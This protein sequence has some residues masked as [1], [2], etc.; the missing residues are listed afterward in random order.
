MS[1]EF[2][3]FDKAP[4][5]PVV[6]ISRWSFGLREVILA[7]IAGILL[8]MCLIL[9]G[10]FGSTNEKLANVPT[11]SAIV[12]KHYCTSV[13]CLKTATRAS[14]LMNKS[15]DPC[16]NFYQYACGNYKKLKSAFHY[17][18]GRNVILDLRE[19]NEDRIIDIMEQ[20]IST[21][22]DNAAE[23]KL[24]K[25]FRSCND[26]YTREKQRGL[27]FLTQVLPELGGWKVLGTWDKDWDVSKALKKV[28]SDFW[29]DALY[30]PRVEYNKDDGEGKIISLS[31]AGTGKLMYPQWY[32]Q[33]YYKTVV[34]DYKKFIRRVGQLLVRDAATFLNQTQSNASLTEELLEEFVNDTYTMEYQIAA[35]DAFDPDDLEE[36][37]YKKMS[38]N[39][40]KGVTNNVIDWTEQLS[41]LFNEARITGN[42]EVEVYNMGYFSGLSTY[43]QSL[44]VQD[45]KRILH[46]YFIW[47]VAESY[48]Q[49]MSWEYIHANREVYVDL[50][51]RPNFSGLYRYCFVV[52]EHHMMDALNYLYIEQFMSKENKQTAHD[53]TDNIRL[54]LKTQI[55]KTP[56]MDERTRIYAQEKLDQLDLKIGYPDWMANQGEIDDM[57]TSLMVNQ[58]DFFGNLLRMN[59]FRRKLW[60]EHL[61]SRGSGHEEWV[62]AAYDTAA[63]YSMQYNEVAAPAGFLQFPIYDADQPHFSSFG[64]FGSIMGK[65]LH[66]FVDEW[67]KTVDKNGEF[68]FTEKGLGSWWSNFTETQYKPAKQ[69]VRNVYSNI[70]RTVLDFNDRWTTIKVNASYAASHA[71]NWISGVK[72]ALLGY[73]DWAMKKTLSERVIP[74]LDMSYD[75]MIFLAHAQT[76]CEVEGRWSFYIFGDLNAELKVNMA[77][78]QMK[79]FSKAFQCKKNAKMNHVKKCQYY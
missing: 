56:W 17:L 61:N 67:G 13:G 5:I 71:I 19:Q 77:L 40:L 14:S 73:Q 18:V 69:C 75:Q 16:E 15:V 21:F 48:V 2:K 78:G 6:R 4:I 74:G 76:N 32:L 11:A 57:Y 9:A 43:L 23:R 51:G 38:L 42:T 3:E 41:Y 33:D 54:A 68:M 53:I 44:P 70:T 28:Q 26:M 34:E 39:V 66:R 29:V 36:N 65:F 7:I 1:E 46:N 60:N 27:P 12:G 49:E 58:S 62:H 55:S 24:K 10:L 63:S 52:S 8:I 47:R 25:F 31:A 79:E 37:Y 30:G 64:S 22:H 59:Q 50:H 20:P 72:L 45:R 35:L